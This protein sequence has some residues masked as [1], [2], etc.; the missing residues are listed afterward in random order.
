MAITSFPFDSDFIGISPQG[1]PI[2]DRGASSLEWARYVSRIF[3]NGFF[4]DSATSL[5]VETS[6]GMNLKINEGCAMINGRQAIINGSETVTLPLAASLPRIDFVVLRLNLTQPVRAVVPAVVS[7]TP[8]ATPSEPSLT[9]N[10]SIWEIALAKITV[11]ASVA[12]IL[13]AN[14]QDVRYY[15]PYCGKVTFLGE[16]NAVLPKY[17]KP[18]IAEY[19][20]AG[21][22]TWT[23]PEEYDFVDVFMLGAGGNAADVPYNSSGTTDSGGGGGG[24]T[25]FLDNYNVSAKT[26][27]TIVIGSGG[28]VTSFDGVT[29]SPGANSVLGTGLGGAGSSGGGG[30]NGGKGGDNGSNGYTSN[31][32]P[33]GAAGQSYMAY[34]PNPNNPLA[35][36]GAGGGG[37]AYSGSGT[38]GVSDYGNGGKG[39]AGTRGQGENGTGNGCGGGGSTINYSTTEKTTVPGGKGSPGMIQIYGYKK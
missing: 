26:T 28:Q 25:K 30:T 18:L 14:I 19:R 33:T 3:S 37:G 8:A 38:G 5:K 31:N 2:G 35:S 34:H 11:P 17:P 1:V 20:T 36:Y 6:G 13:A 22:F 10:D 4:L 23:K 7:G 32:Q 12:Q 15:L 39:G 9:R 29:V 21:T 16:L 24:Y 27:I